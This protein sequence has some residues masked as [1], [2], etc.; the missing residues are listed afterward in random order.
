MVTSPGST[1][2][3]PWGTS[4]RV[5]V[6]VGDDLDRQRRCD[7]T[8]VSGAGCCGKRRSIGAHRVG[9]PFGEASG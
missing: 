6:H 4:S 3:R 8:R 2:P 9:E 1:S 5:A 7:G